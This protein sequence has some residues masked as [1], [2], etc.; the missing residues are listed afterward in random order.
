M[1][2]SKH[3]SYDQLIDHVQHGEKPIWLLFDDA[4]DTYW[5]VE[6]WNGLFKEVMSN[7]FRSNV[8]IVCFA[9]CGSPSHWNN[10]NRHGTPERISAAA[11]MGLFPTQSVKDALL[12]TRAEF[13][14]FMEQ[15]DELVRQG[16]WDASGWPMLD[17]HL[18]HYIFTTSNGHIGAIVGLLN[19]AAVAAASSLICSHIRSQELIG[20]SLERGTYS[21]PFV[22]ETAAAI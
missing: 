12:F 19:L 2:D 14:G 11:C 7:G 16:V 13:D 4:Q 20:D 1:G 22:T 21:C 3:K 10:P 18:K 5:D 15:C 17:D 8:R 9:L 6:L